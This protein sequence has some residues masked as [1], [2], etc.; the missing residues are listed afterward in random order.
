M[1][2]RLRDLRINQV[3]FWYQQ[4]IRE[5]DILDEDGN[6]TGETQ[7]V[8]SNPVMAYARISPSTGQAESSPF[9]IN[10]DYDK[11]ISTVQNLPIDEYSRLF[12]DIVPVINADGSTDTEPD[13]YCVVPKKDLQQ[14]VWAVKKIR[15]AIGDGNQTD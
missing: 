13:Y 2:L 1:A 8:Y 6:L 9:G 14:N 4:F 7:K 10:T 12:I 3:P 15:A 11:A 5:E